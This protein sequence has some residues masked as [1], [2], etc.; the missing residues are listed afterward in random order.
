[1]S[2]Q[3]PPKPQSALTNPQVIT[4]I[5]GGTVTLLAAILGILPTVLNRAPQATAVVIVTATPFPTAAEAAQV[6]PSITPAE[7][8]ATTVPATAV[9]VM[10][11][12]VAPSVTPL[13]AIDAP[14]QITPQVIAS[15]PPTGNVLLMYDDV[16][17]T[18]LNQD[19]RG[20]SFSNVTFRSANG[21]FDA[22]AWG[23][24]LPSGFCLRLRDAAAS[25]RQPPAQ[26]GGNL[27]SL[28]EVSGSS[29]FW[30]GVDTFD[31]T[32]DGQVIVT[33]PTASGQCLVNIS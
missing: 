3:Q 15:P 4:A 6:V 31:V 5:I 2:E 26:C 24:S 19:S 22:R 30:R 7:P 33:C 11:T 10:P 17:F 8:T 27:Y 18:V 16:S 1:M 13:P 9:P 25:Q 32:R 23:S 28:L 29:I 20:L 21:S 12:E 14:T